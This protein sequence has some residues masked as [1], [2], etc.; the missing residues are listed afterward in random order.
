MFFKF[1]AFF[2]FLKPTKVVWVCFGCVF[3]EER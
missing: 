1:F 2:G 3:R